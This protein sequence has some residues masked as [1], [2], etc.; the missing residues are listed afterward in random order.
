MESDEPMTHSEAVEIRELIDQHRDVL[1]WAKI[2]MQAAKRREAM[3]AKI[4]E[5][6][7]GHLLWVVVVGLG[8]AIWQTVK[9]LLRP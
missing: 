9:Q 8:V 4:T 6:T 3:F 7:L 1:S 2:Q 5:S